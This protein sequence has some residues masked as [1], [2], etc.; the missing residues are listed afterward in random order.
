MPSWLLSD[1]YAWLWAIS[2]DGGEHKLADGTGAMIVIDDQISFKGRDGGNRSAFKGEIL[3]DARRSFSLG[4]QIDQML[5]DI[6]CSEEPNLK[7]QFKL[8]SG[9]LQAYK[10]FLPLSSGH[11]DVAAGVWENLELLGRADKILEDLFLQF[12]DMRVNRQD[13]LRKKIAVLI[14]DA[15]TPVAESGA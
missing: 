8:G 5:V 6:T 11:E 9:G 2:E 10:A 4:M 3:A 12:L 1:F 7:Y 15:G 14:V 13:D